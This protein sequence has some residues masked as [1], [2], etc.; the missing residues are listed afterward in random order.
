MA[1]KI[2]PIDIW[3][4]GQTQIGEYFKVACINDNYEDTATNLWQIFTLKV[5]E[6]G[7][8]EPNFQIAQGYLTITGDEYTE[9]GEQPAMAINDWIYN[10][11]ANKLNLTII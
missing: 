11:V 6:D 9:W 10:W 4:E 2:Q 8:E 3:A 1:K 7:T 5:M